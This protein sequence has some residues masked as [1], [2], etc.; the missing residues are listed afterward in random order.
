MSTAAIIVCVSMHCNVK[1]AHYTVKQR[2]LCITLGLIDSCPLCCVAATALQD[3]YAA[4]WEKRDP[5]RMLK[6]N[7]SFAAPRLDTISS[8]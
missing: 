7:V 1:H 3:N 8:R 5:W 2:A 6:K 4:V